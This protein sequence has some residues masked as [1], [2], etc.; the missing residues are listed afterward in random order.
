[1]LLRFRTRIVIVVATARICRFVRCAALMISRCALRWR[2]LNWW[3]L[4]FWSWFRILVVCLY[5]W[6]VISNG[7]VRF[8]IVMVCCLCLMR[9]FACSVVLVIGMV[10]NVTATRLILSFLLRVLCWVMF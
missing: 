2:G 3:L 6:L 5:F 4:C 10:C 7:W 1:M 8:V 9:L